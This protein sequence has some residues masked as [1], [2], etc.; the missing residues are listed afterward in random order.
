VAGWRIKWEEQMRGGWKGPSWALGGNNSGGS[1]VGVGR[2]TG[3]TAPTRVMVDD[4]RE[5]VVPHNGLS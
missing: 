1:R 3:R 5:C 2:D 4:R